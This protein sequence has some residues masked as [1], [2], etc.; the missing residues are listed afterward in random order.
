MSPEQIQVIFASAYI[1]NEE[2]IP[3]TVLTARSLA[4]FAI[5]GF[6]VFGWSQIGVEFLHLITWG[7]LLVGSISDLVRYR[8]LAL[9]YNQ[10]VAREIVT[11]MQIRIEEPRLSTRPAPAF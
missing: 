5:P 2:R 8:T 3:H 6:S 11:N 1:A 10:R 4:W 7:L 9:L